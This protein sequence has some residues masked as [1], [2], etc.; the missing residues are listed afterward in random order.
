MWSAAHDH[1][2]QLRRCTLM[3]DKAISKLGKREA[4][5]VIKTPTQQND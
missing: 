1:F 5:R 2:A 3:A 4:L